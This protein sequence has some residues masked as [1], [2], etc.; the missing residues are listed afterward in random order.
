MT[1]YEKWIDE[2]VESGEACGLSLE[3]AFEAGVNLV[4]SKW[5]EL[6][7]GSDPLEALTVLDNWFL[8]QLGKD[9]VK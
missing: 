7:E 3:S 1:D 8:D 5:D 4:R 9:G 2:Q 6:S